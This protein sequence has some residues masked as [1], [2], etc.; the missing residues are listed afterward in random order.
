[1]ILT[2]ESSIDF[3]CVLWNKKIS[4]HSPGDVHKSKY[5]IKLSDRVNLFGFFGLAS[6]RKK[7]KIK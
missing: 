4:A 5:Q 6:S 3:L 1:M 2:S 7:E